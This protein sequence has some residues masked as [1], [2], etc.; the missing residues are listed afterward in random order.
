[1]CDLFGNLKLRCVG[2]SFLTRDQTQAPSHWECGI[3]ATGPP[4]KPLTLFY[5]YEMLPSD[6]MHAGDCST[7]FAQGFG[8][9]ENHHLQIPDVEAGRE[10]MPRGIP[11]ACSF[12][13]SFIQTKGNIWSARVCDQSW[14]FNSHQNGLCQA[15][16][17]SGRPCLAQWEPNTTE[18]LPALFQE[19]VLVVPEVQRGG[20]TLLPSTGNPLGVTCGEGPG[21]PDPLLGV[22]SV[23]QQ[24][25]DE[26]TVTCATSQIPEKILVL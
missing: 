9:P 12:I 19:A 18:Q 15:L 17:S 5:R 14:G 8:G 6:C 2:S 3:L 13:H 4:W 26:A 7:V 23:A 21:C 24:G 10:T 16:R 20:L 25:Q 11:I 22:P 1:M